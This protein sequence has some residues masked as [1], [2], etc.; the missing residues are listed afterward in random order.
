M[1]HPNKTNGAHKFLANQKIKLYPLGT[2]RE[3]NQKGESK[4]TGTEV[5]K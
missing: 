5:K 4:I 3:I 2:K 1:A